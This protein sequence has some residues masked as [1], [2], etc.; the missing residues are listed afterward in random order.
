M[1]QLLEGINRDKLLEFL[2]EYAEYDSKFAN[3]VNVR[4]G[5]LVFDDEL[6]KIMN[7]IERTLNGV[8]DYSTHD[9]WGY[10]NIYTGDIFEEIRARVSQGHVRLAFA[11]TELLYR[12][13]VELF[14]YQA[15]CEISDEAEYCVS[16]MSDIADIA[17]SEDDKEHIIQHCLELAALEDA[18]NYGVDHEDKLL[19]IV[20]KLKIGR[21]HV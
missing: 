3:A 13:L 6:E 1:R 5:K 17:M 15:E 4:F 21:A 20:A 8:S 7:K 10:V 14:E 9:E 11:A 18:K 16:M 12:K 19:K 2:V